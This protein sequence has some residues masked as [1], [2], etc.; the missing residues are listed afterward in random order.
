MNEDGKVIALVILVEIIAVGL[1]LAALTAKLMGFCPTAYS[2]IIAC[3]H[4]LRKEQV[5]NGM[6]HSTPS[7]HD[8]F[9]NGADPE[10]KP[11]NGNRP[12]NGHANGIGSFANDN[13][14]V[15]PKRKRGRPPKNPPTNGEIA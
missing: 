11:A 15:Q 1:D 6:F 10:L 12:G 13:E 2:L 7:H 4:V 9:Q 8:D 3:R 5:I 14:P